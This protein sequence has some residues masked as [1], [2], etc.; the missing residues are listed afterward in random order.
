MRLS[1]DKADH[2]YHDLAKGG[3][4]EATV[5]GQTVMDWV[6]ADEEQGVVIDDRD[7]AHSGSVVIRVIP[8]IAV[9]AQQMARAVLHGMR[10]EYNTR[11]S[12][13]NPTAQVQT[14]QGE[15]VVAATA[16]VGAEL[17][18]EQPIVAQDTS[19]PAQELPTMRRLFGKRTSS[20][21]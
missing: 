11:A 1:G 10:T 20:S 16:E 12:R 8:S 3:W 19:A 15:G 7:V 6:T 17:S 18:D 14:A 5:D 4:Y 2:A 9:G 21:R 13:A